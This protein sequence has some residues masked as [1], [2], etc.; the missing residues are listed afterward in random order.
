MYRIM[1]KCYGLL[2]GVTYPNTSSYLPGCDNDILEVYKFLK[3][4]GYNE[5][6]ILCDTDIF[7]QNSVSV[8]TSIPTYR[9]IVYSL[10]KMIY[11]ARNNPSGKIFLHYSGHGTQVSDNNWVFDRELR[12]WRKEEDDGRDECIVSGDMGLIRDDQLKWLFSFMPSS[13]T[14]FSLMDSCHSGTAFDLKYYLKSPNNPVTKTRQ[15][16]LNAYVLMLSGCKDE[17]FSQSSKFNGKWYGV[18]SYAFLQLTKYMKT[19]N[20]KELSICDFWRYMGIICNDFPQIPQAS[21]SKNEFNNMKITCT[22][23]IFELVKSQTFTRELSIVDEKGNGISDN[24]SWG[25]VEPVK[26]KHKYE[27]KNYYMKMR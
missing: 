10:F 1:G 7:E 6:D 14:L 17:Q 19:Y 27:K 4:S 24:R 18:M 15:T 13:I 12:K 23:G 11:W 9:N 22:D 26:N 3:G 21:C 25:M 16:D 20:V 2:I 5:V 8:V